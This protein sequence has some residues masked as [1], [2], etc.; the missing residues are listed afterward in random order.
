MS[1][2]KYFPI[3]DGRPRHAGNDGALA[4]QQN[5]SHGGLWAG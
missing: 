5:L 1:A 4:I 2:D 3:R